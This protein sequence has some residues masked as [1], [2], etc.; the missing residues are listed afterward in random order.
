MATILDLLVRV[1]ADVSGF[2]QNMEQAGTSVESFVAAVDR[3]QSGLRTI[4]IV[5]TGAG[6]AILGG[7]ALATR[8]ASEAQQE[9]VLLESALKAAGEA[10]QENVKALVD[11]ASA[12]QNTTKFSDEQ[13]KASQRLLLVTGRNTEE[14][15]AAIPAIA[16]FAVAT[17]RDLGDATL[18]VAKA[19]SGNVAL[20]RRYGIAIQEGI[21]PS[22]RMAKVLEALRAASEGAAEAQARTLGG[23]LALLRNRVNDLLERIGEP[24]LAPLARIVKGLADAIGA[25]TTFAEAN[26][27]LVRSLGFI[28]AA[29]GLVLFGGGGIIFFLSTL[30]K[31][32][33]ILKAVAAGAGVLAG[34]L[35]VLGLAVGVSPFG[36]LLAALSLLIVVIPL[37]IANFDALK[38]KA[39]Q[40]L[41]FISVAARELALG[42]IQLHKAVLTLNFNEAARSVNR[43]ANA[44]GTAADEANKVANAQKTVASSTDGMGNAI[45]KAIRDF[46]IIEEETKTAI[47]GFNLFAA[48]LDSFAADT[49]AKKLSVPGLNKEQVTAELEAL[50]KVE[51]KNARQRLEDTI[52]ALGV[53]RDAAVKAFGEKSEKVLTI[54]TKLSE[55]RKQLSQIVLQDVAEFAQRIVDIEEAAAKQRQDIER[56]TTQRNLDLFRLQEET[57]IGVLRRVVALQASLEKTIFDARAVLLEIGFRREESQLTA[58]AAR[59]AQLVRD[60]FLEESEAAKQNA[61]ERAE[62]DQTRLES[63]LKQAQKRFEMGVAQ[64]QRE[65]ALLVAEFAA[66]DSVLTAETNARASQLRAEQALRDAD[67]QSTI[68]KYKLETEAL[69]NQLD[70]QFDARKNAQQEAITAEAGVAGT[71]EQ[72][73]AALD[74]ATRKHTEN[75][76]EQFRRLNETVTRLEQQRVDLANNANAAIV[77]NAQS[78]NEQRKANQF[79]L[80]AALLQKDEEDLAARAQLSDFFSQQVVKQEELIAR[81]RAELETAGVPEHE[82]RRILRPQEDFLSGLER[83]SRT[84]TGEVTS[85]ANALETAYNTV[86]GNITAGV[87]AL[88]TKI[89]ELIDPT[90]L[91]AFLQAFAPFLTQG[92]VAPTPI[93]QAGAGAQVNQFM[94][95]GVTVNLSAD[96]ANLF[97]KFIIMMLGSEGERIFNEII[98]RQPG[99]ATA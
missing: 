72:K 48:K 85:Q 25:V 26:P 32:L 45:R 68:A 74:E 79:D 16:D 93:V 19:L 13:V 55:A 6:L 61:A 40:V 87:N 84:L 65:R 15:R 77:A 89:G 95:N 31:A 82:I 41:T 88:K 67:L 92:V 30:V 78:A 36:V 62:L 60:G 44:F 43:M 83:T 70:I 52:R 38:T 96:E 80:N 99:G 5:A 35:R 49:A 66:K 11:Q 63:E 58:N 64:R 73:Q 37:V 76:A 23:A 53:E 1:G 42:F 69:L 94:V 9:Q 46:E 28:A 3:A 8:A 17:G 56:Q 75:R 22:E 12:L 81:R 59:R 34:A 97:Q 51:Q 24:F 20:L 14:V 2:K 7:L 29:L 57:R 50:R 47:A 4:G 54:E 86:F 27:V 91:Q 98:K 21:P 33:A 90:K 18:V 39:V 71:P 10:S